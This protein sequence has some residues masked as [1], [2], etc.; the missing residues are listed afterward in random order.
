M[1]IRQHMSAILAALIC[2]PG[3]LHADIV[4]VA[5][6]Y[7]D[8]HD[9]GGDTDWVLD[10]T[11][12]SLDATAFAIITGGPG[13]DIPDADFRLNSTGIYIYNF[14]AIT[15]F[16]TGSGSFTGTFTVGG[17]LLTG[18]V[19]LTID[20]LYMDMTAT[21]SGSYAGTLVYSGGSLAGSLNSGLIVG[22][23]GT[24]GSIDYVDAKL[25]AVVPIPA[26]AWLFASGLLG[27]VAVS[28]RKFS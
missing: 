4:D 18:T 27:L 16:G 19:D 7:L 5:L 17:G 1:K 22:E 11:N 26:T 10:P 2:M 13:I 3:I 21:F 28:R 14:D 20:T 12:F 8:I 24:L 6:P 23:I 9:S 15:G 25:G